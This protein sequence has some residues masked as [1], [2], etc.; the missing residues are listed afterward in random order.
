[1]RARDLALGLLGVA[2]LGA[3]VRLLP[4]LRFAVWGSDT[5]EYHRLTVQVLADGFLS[6]DYPGWGIA[7]PWFPGLYAVTAGVSAM[8]G[9][10]PRTSLE[11]VV[12]ALAGLAA[13]GVA[14]LA[15]RV[16]RDGPAAILAGASVAVLMPHV[17]ATSHA[18]PGA[19][20]HLLLLAALLLVWD[21]ERDRAAWP[22]LLLALV[23]LV[24]THHLSTYMLFLA[25]G[26]A[27]AWRALLVAKPAPPRHR[28]HVAALG[29]GL[30]VALAWWQWA[31]PI[32]EQVVPSQSALGLGA[33]ALVAALGLAALA[34]LPALRLR[35]LPAW[36]YRPRFKAP[37]PGLRRVG[38]V[39][40]VLFLGLV[41]VGLVGIPGTTVTITLDALPW[42]L[43]LAVLVAFAS[44]GMAWSKWRPRGALVYGW[45]LAVL[46]SLA[47]M[48][49][50]RSVVLLPYRHAEYLLEPLGLLAGVGLAALLVHAGRR[51]W[52]GPALAGVAAL[53]LA[54]AAIAYPPPSILAGFQEG[55]TAEEFAAV[56]WARQHV[57]LGPDAVIAADHRLSSV[58]FGYA[59]LNATWEYAPLTFHA[60]SFEEARAEMAAVNAPSG[61]KRVDAVFLAD[62][63]REGLALLQW[64]PARPLSPAA[65]DKFEQD[66]RYVP[67]C[68]SPTVVIYAVDWTGAAA[69][70]DAVPSCG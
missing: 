20:G 21:A 5:G 8:T 63:M 24:A 19:L 60:A 56:Q 33:F 62:S 29:A 36:R 45:V 37:G 41:G 12:P 49:A 10:D 4:L 46:G 42:I 52:R 35:G 15:Y 14:L 32:R 40:A 23:A 69:R 6:L 61:A 54:N 70:P 38:A 22:L 28:A 44:L 1:M 7:Y 43:P 17:L 9:L 11:V 39:C 57:R 58:L 65:Q 66:P 64:E 13:L 59:G 31:A 26:G 50:L 55:T 51:G 30:A 34:A 3:A 48:A 53:L 68:R 16:F 2:L 27:A 67:L 47:V 25:L 18:M